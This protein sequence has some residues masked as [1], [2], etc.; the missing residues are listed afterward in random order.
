MIRKYIHLLK[1]KWQ[2]KAVILM[3]HQIAEAVCDPWELAVSPKNFEEQLHILKKHFNVVPLA[4]LAEAVRKR[5]LRRRMVAIT[6]DDGTEDNFTC[7][8]PL[9]EKYQLPATF[10]IPTAYVGNGEIFWWEELQ[11]IFLMQ[12]KLPQ[13]LTLSFDKETYFFDL[14]NTAVLP[15]GQASVTASW[16]AE[17]PI[18]N[19][20]IEVFFK[21]WQLLKPL[22]YEEQKRVVRTLRNWAGES[23]GATTPRVLSRE[24]LLMLHR[25]PL[26]R[27]EAHTLHH[28]ALAEQS[29]IVQAY[30]IQESKN[31]LEHWLADDVVGFAYPYGNYDVTTRQ[32]VMQSG[33]HYAVTTCALPVTNESD[34]MELPRYQVKNW[35]GEQFALQLN[36]WRS[37]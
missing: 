19:T 21:L 24:A 4:T 32:L 6:F 36:L 37:N 13:R 12:K 3:Y 7:A 27:V 11:R 33:Y 30:E 23:N 9:L 31:Q 20:R 22:A 14:G 8:A 15:P 29:E 10:F 25:N 1:K 18:Q 35:N 17:R 5:T 2:T 26:F 28:P 34:V 16:N